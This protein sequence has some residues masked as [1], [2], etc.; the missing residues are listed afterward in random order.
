MARNDEVVRAIAADPYLKERKSPNET[1][2]QLYLKE[3]SF[4]CP[5]CG[6]DLQH[7]KKK[8]PISFMRL[9]IFFQTDRPMNNT[10]N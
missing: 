9:P 2:Q 8:K 7:R 5:L 4:T 6:K 1:E 3:I 10:N